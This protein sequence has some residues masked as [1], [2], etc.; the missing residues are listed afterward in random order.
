MTT[1]PKMIGYISD[2]G[3]F[4]DVMTFNQFDKDYQVYYTPVFTNPVA[5]GSF[6]DGFK[7]GMQ[8]AILYHKREANH[9][10]SS[11]GQLDD[12]P[13]PII[14]SHQRMH[15]KA[16][17][18]RLSLLTGDNSIEYMLVTSPEEFMREYLFELETG[19]TYQPSEHEHKLIVDAIAAYTSDK[20]I[21]DV[22]KMV[23]GE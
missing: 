12:V 11:D 2:R 13:F 15:I 5:G 4:V 22:R 3:T 23:K 10:G 6:G 1:Q 17:Q 18:A 16:L 9:Y 19:G 20:R 21:L 8:E 7:A 14:A